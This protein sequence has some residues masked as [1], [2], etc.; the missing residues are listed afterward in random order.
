MTESNVQPFEFKGNPVATVT[1]SEGAVL[2]CAKHVA[3][4]LGYTNT[5]KAIK[6]HCKGITN[7]YPL[8][9]A[10]GIQQ[11]VFIT[12]GDV[13]RLIASSKLP[14]AV[15]FEHWLFDEVVPQIRRTGGY[16]PQA[17]SPEETMARAV[18]IAQKTIEDQK[19]QLEA[20]RP[21]VLFADA[22]SASKTDILVG[23][24]AKILKGNGIDMGGTR[25]FA[26]LRENGWLMKTGSS[27]NMPTQKSME[28]GLFRIKETEITHSDGH[29]TVNK[30][31][32]V[33]GK[34]QS[35]FVNLFLAGKVAA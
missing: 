25:L 32:K 30:T 13:Y 18:L 20:Q 10:G 11:M 3:T 8:E 16:I 7:R 4:A 9:T 35:F 31:P 21:K 1:T 27:R 34:G 5:N 33:T 22:V 26:W 28:L 12:E 19:K 17:E 14:S 6:D 23:K 24:L 29:I 15:E 2:F